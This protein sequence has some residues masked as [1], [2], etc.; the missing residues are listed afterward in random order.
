MAPPMEDIRPVQNLE[1]NLLELNLT[2]KD[3]CNIPDTVLQHTEV[4][5]LKL[6]FNK[7]K[8]LPKG[9]SRLSKLKYLWLDFNEFEEFPE[10]VCE[11][12]SLEH[13]YLSQ[14][15]LRHVSSR[16]G[17]LRNLKVLFLHK[18]ELNELPNEIFHI[19]SIVD[20]HI[21]EN[22]LVELPEDIGLLE[23]LTML[24]GWDNQI[25][26]LPDSVC[27][28]KKLRL[29]DFAMNQLQVLPDGFGTALSGVEVS[30]YG[31]PLVQP[32][33]E[34]CSQGIKAIADYQDQL[35]S[36]EDTVDPC[37]KMLLVGETCG[38]KTSL[39]N[40][41]VLN[42]S[43]L[44]DVLSRTHGIE[45][46][47]WDTGNEIKVNIYDFGV[48]NLS[49]YCEGRFQVEIGRWLDMLA[50]RVPGAMVRVIGTH[51][52][53]LSPEEVRT[54]SS[55]ITDQMVTY[56]ADR[57]A[58]LQVIIDKLE[59]SMAHPAEMITSCNIET[60]FQELSERL[61]KAKKTAHQK[62][63]IGQ[64]VIPVSSASGLASI[65]ALREEIV[66]MAHNSQNFPELRRKLPRSWTIL[67]KLLSAKSNEA[68]CPLYITMED[69]M[70][71]G[72]SAGLLT[73]SS[74]I[75]SLN[76]LH[77][78]GAVLYYE[79]LPWFVFPNPTHLIDIFKALLKDHAEMKA[80]Y[81][82]ISWLTPIERRRIDDN[83]T[84]QAI[85]PH[86]VVSSL[87][88]QHTGQSKEGLDLL[89]ALMLNFG[90]CHRLPVPEE[91]SPARAYT[92]S[93]RMYLFPWY[94]RRL[95][96]A[97]VQWTTCPQE[98]EEH[99]EL[100]C[101]MA[102]PS[103]WG[104][105]ERWCVLSTRHLSYRQAWEN[106]M[107]A[108]SQADM[109]VAIMMQ[110]EEEGGASTLH[111]TGRGTRECL[112][113]VWATVKSI[114]SEL[115]T[116]LKEWPGLYTDTFICCAHCV[117]THTE[118]PEYFSGELLHHTAPGSV[119]SLRCPRTRELVDV[120][121]VYPPSTPTD[122]PVSKDCVQ[123]VSQ[124]L[125]K[126]K[127]RPLGRAVGLEEG[128]IEAIEVQHSRDLNEMKYQ[129]LLCW[130]RKA[131]QSATMSVLISALRNTAVQENAIAD[132]LET[133]AK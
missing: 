9:I 86:K 95:K 89:L 101:Q 34:V 21:S 121:L 104:L 113:T 109:S 44:V 87:L 112:T 5:V 52:D 103:P 3:L 66:C 90:I 68:D 111:V 118:S 110:H 107:Y 81:F 4:E 2:G 72:S 16:I 117:K 56:Q 93:D 74:L 25:R 49:A 71:M 12:T 36:A 133:L 50:V 18:N 84:H 91:N 122:Q 69:C 76:Y 106:G 55:L 92:T 58:T 54:K 82:K 129:M 70:L 30:L 115:H 60:S 40:A 42:K 8:T 17:R 57:D 62:L 85:L 94:L 100:V 59:H 75:N 78:T 6:S 45:I 63:C 37:L 24:R 15:K 125:S 7:L 13:L 32:P 47:P 105:F 11:L 48:V 126:T 39:K 14:N 61:D 77:R 67:E 128:D 23:N 116:L 99:I 19:P 102:M 35:T 108:F 38:G 88:K 96:P 97:D 119:R 26:R 41:L 120:S 22:R 43:Q 114:V 73:Q 28:L 79:A 80:E 123:L 131:G 1:T 29:I 33:F 46:T 20:L 98:N 27:R 130:Q 65:Q 64:V 10:V 51:I 132:E 124:K 53:K 31:N 127:W 83:F